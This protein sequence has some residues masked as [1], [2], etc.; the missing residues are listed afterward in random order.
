MNLSKLIESYRPGSYGDDWTWDDE[1][2]DLFDREPDGMHLLIEDIS[3]NG[4]LTPV[5]LGS[6]GRVWD[7]HHRIVAALY[8]EL[9]SIPIVHS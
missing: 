9:P 3:K 1:A 5:L 2:E 6:D 7:G 4:V 8:L